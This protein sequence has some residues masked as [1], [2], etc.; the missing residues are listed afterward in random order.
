MKKRNVD[1]KSPSRLKSELWKKLRTEV[2][3]ATLASD[4]SEFLDKHAGK[5]TPNQNLANNL[6]A[7]LTQKYS[8]SDEKAGQLRRLIEHHSDDVAAFLD[9]ISFK[10]GQA[11]IKTLGG[12]PQPTSFTDLWEALLTAP[13]KLPPSQNE[14]PLPDNDPL[15]RKKRRRPD[16]KARP[17]ACDGERKPQTDMRKGAANTATA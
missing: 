17:N 7:Y 4:I 2:D 3:L 12:H 6:A 1:R 16:R 9:E 11:L 10:E 5:S 8:V 13:D 14:I 15:R